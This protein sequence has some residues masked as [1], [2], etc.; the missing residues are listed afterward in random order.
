LTIGNVC[1]ALGL[2]CDVNVCAVPSLDNPVKD[3]TASSP[4][5]LWLSDNLNVLVV[6]AI[7]KY[8]VLSTKPP[9]TAAFSLS[10]FCPTYNKLVHHL[11]SHAHYL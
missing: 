8:V 7:T 11:Q 5:L 6:D 2:P 4:Q 10:E 9:I 3:T 1:P